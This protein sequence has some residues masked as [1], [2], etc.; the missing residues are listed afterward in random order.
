M[1]VRP[2]GLPHPWGAISCRKAAPLTYYGLGADERQSQTSSVKGLVTAAGQMHKWL[3]DFKLVMEDA[4]G[5]L[6]VSQWPWGSHGRWWKGPC[7]QTKPPPPMRQVD[8]M[9]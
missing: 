6:Q 3:K 7:L 5:T 4:G 1:S 2:S 9:P 8:A